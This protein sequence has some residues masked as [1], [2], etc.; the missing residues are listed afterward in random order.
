MG[1]IVHTKTLPVY[2]VYAP[3]GEF[4]KFSIAIIAISHTNTYWNLKICPRCI[5]WEIAIIDIENF[6][7]SHVGAYTR[8]T[9]EVWYIH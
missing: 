4:E 6:S 9:G 3:T 2:L 8:C 5:V 7:K 1:I